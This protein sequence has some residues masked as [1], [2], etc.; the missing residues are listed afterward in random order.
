MKLTNFEKRL[1]TFCCLIIL[2]FSYFLYDD[3][4]FS[5][6]RQ[7]ANEKVAQL[8]V[9]N[10]DVRFKSSENFS[11]MNAREQ[12]SLYEFDSL[13]TGESSTA[14]LQ[15]NDGST[16]RIDGQSLIVLSM[17]NGKLVLDLKSGSLSGDLSSKSELL[18]RTKDGLEKI[19]G[20]NSRQIRLERNFSGSTLQKI[21]RNPA[22][23]SQ[24]LWTSPPDFKI[25]K[26]DP[27]TYQN[28]SWQKSQQIEEVI[29]EISASPDFSLLDSSIKTKNREAGIPLA[30]LPGKYFTRLKGY[31]LGRNQVASS[32]VHTFEVIDKKRSLL[33]PPILKTTN[34]QHSDEFSF[35]PLVQWEPVQE[36][37]QYRFELSKTPRFDQVINY[38]TS[39]SQLAWTGA[40]PGSYF[41][42]VYSMKGEDISLPSE[43]GTLE[44]S[45]QAPQLNPIAPLVIRSEKGVVTP[46][47]VDLKWNHQSK[48]QTKY[49]VEVSE[50]GTFRNPKVSLNQRG[51]AS[52]QVQKPGQYYVRVF[53]TNEV[54][55][56]VSPSSNIERFNY[57]IKNLLKEPLL[58]R[59]FNDTTVFL[60]QDDNPYLWL[61]WKPVDDAEQFQ[62][63]IATDPEFTRVIDS[64]TVKSSNEKFL[65]YL[66]SKRLAYGKYYWRVKSISET[67]KADS[68]WSKPNLF[69][70]LHKK[71]E[72]FFE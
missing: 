11:W 18:V 51:P 34:I 50:D 9:K 29:V 57:Q 35:P 40:K 67:E 39:A 61:T 68:Q 46:Q 65:R 3:S 59:P 10:Q 38:E 4:L 23:L 13:F 24:I 48:G 28:L 36:A 19:G 32:T 42:R 62:V 63:E 33:F 1:L 21:D 27:R 26:Q 41:F 53:A 56:P 69:Y 64:A 16:L 66:M 44:V 70:L 5:E 20:N 60:Q 54:G 49:R 22:A 12:E 8:I 15:L 52:V 45:S 31:N 14:V 7:S 25:N 55:E 37:A 30:L 17:E 72:I 71:K 43:I 6:E 2:L 58:I 47:K